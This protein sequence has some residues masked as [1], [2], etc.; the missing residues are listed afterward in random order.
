VTAL[1]VAFG[2][3]WGATALGLSIPIG[4]FLAGLALSGSLYA[5]QVFAELLPLRDAFVAVFFT[6]VGMLLVPADA[7]AHPTL[8]LG[9]LALVAGKG[10]L[11]FVV[12][13]LLWRSV[14]LGV[15]T[16]FALAQ[17]GEF[18][19][20][21]SRAGVAAG[22]MPEGGE[23][24]F[25]AA[26][27][28]T[29][30]ATPLAMRLGRRLADA[31]GA[32]PSATAAPALHDHVIVLGCGT[33]GHAVARVLRETGIPFVSVDLDARVVEAARR[34]GLPARFGDASR[35]AVLEDLGAPAARATVVTVGDPGA[36]RR[37]VSLL[38]QMSPTMRIIVRAQ[39]VA[40]V[41]ELERLGADDVVPSEFETSI[42]L[43]VRLLV[44][45]GVPRHVVR[46]QESL[47]RL[48]RYQALRGVGASAELLAKAGRIIAGGILETAQVM[49]GSAAAGRTIGELALRRKTGA[50]VLSVVRGDGPVAGVG[51]AT[52]LEAGDF[53]VLY[54]AHAAIDRA[55]AV[56]EPRS[57]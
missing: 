36:T 1:V 16:A 32:R 35:R 13:A 56:L 24:S 34:E 22:V 2:T 18:S 15:L 10:V 33:T 29:M 27:I 9:M 54:G 39:R 44:H 25:L 40:E 28:A 53:V 52:R 21:L 57:T 4:T 41:A 49:D 46:V 47:I 42:E 55:L 6:S 11:T 12:V 51:P 7:L 38:R 26:A 17:I 19:F 20:V 3:A 45:L 43:F 23:S 30:A 14:R 5:H 37:I 50:T 8:T 31:G 48:D